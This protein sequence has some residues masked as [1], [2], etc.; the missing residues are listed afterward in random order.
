MNGSIYLFGNFG[1][2]YDQ[3]LFDYT[4]PILRRF[5]KIK[6]TPTL[7][8][9]HRDGDLMYY[10]Y[11]RRLEDNAEHFIGLCCV[12]N[13]SGFLH[14]SKL[15]KVF[16]KELESIISQG[17][18]VGFDN[19]GNIVPRIT[20]LSG[21]QNEIN[22]I[23]AHLK[24]LLSELS[25]SQL[26]PYNYA[27][28]ANSVNKLA[29]TDS[30]TTINDSINN[31]SY[32]YIYKDSDYDSIAITSYR[33]VVRGL[34]SDMNALYQ[35]IEKLKVSNKNL[36][37]EKKRTKLVAWLM[38]G[39]AVFAV[40]F[41]CV[42]TNMSNTITNQLDQIQS[43]KQTNENLI[44]RND[45]LSVDLIN[46]ENDLINK[47]NECDSV[48]NEMERQKQALSLKSDSIKFLQKE[49][50]R[51]EWQISELN[52]SL[53][54]VSKDFA[55]FKKKISSQSLII[56]DVQV[57][58]VEY[59]GNKLVNYGDYISSNSTM[60]LK[61][62]IKYIGLTSEKK[63]IYVKFF[64][65]YGTLRRVTDAPSGYSYKE[66]KNIKIGKQEEEFMGLGG[67]KGYWPAGKYRYEFY[68]DGQSVGTH[69]FIVH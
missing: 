52:K 65:P 16:E 34:K 61:P 21:L 26:P 49:N 31:Y 48:K 11:M 64:D 8:G 19:G 59:N 35:E 25:F 27:V 60:Y 58:N 32:T 20:Q 18:F 12:V 46:K 37:R 42:W 43:L 51:Q 68:C 53:S 22:N 4:E 45:K 54:A 33:G 13:G 66:E 6:D 3:Y 23:S 69:E 30:P 56:T 44:N 24:I 50:N 62:K 29:N 9:I 55:D 63:T 47:E 36:E 5:S 15:F 38:T 57:A 14:I 1:R 41:F 2:G 67:K 39:L 17:I 10:A 7:L 28:N 40:V